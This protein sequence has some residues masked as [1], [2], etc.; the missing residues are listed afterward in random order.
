MPT[1]IYSLENVPLVPSIMDFS[2]IQYLSSK[3]RFNNLQKQLEDLKWNLK[4]D[5]FFSH[6]NSQEN[7][8]F[9]VSINL[10]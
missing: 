4:E 9:N 1:N 7:G 5:T 10:L 3:E 6:K 8:I 2:N